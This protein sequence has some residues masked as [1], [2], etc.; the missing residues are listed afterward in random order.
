MQYR[1]LI[2]EDEPM[3][4]KMLERLLVN[5]GYETTSVADGNE[6][7][8]ALQAD[9]SPK[10]A[11]LDWVMPGM[12]G[13]DVARRVRATLSAAD[14]YVYVILITQ[15]ASKEDI[16][17]GIEAGADD[18]IVKPFDPQELRVRIRAGQRL[19][20]LHTGLMAAKADLE[21]ANS[22][23]RREIQVREKTERQLKRARDQLEKRVSARTLELAESN[24]RLRNEIEVRKR[25][26]E[27]AGESEARLMTFFNTAPD[28]IF[29]KDRSLK[30]TVVNPSME[31]LF[32]LPASGIVGR[33]DKELYG[34][35]A[36]RHLIE[37]DSRVI[38]GETIEEEHTRAVNGAPITVLEVRAPMR[39]ATGEVLGICGISRNITERKM[40]A[41]SP[42]LSMQDYSSTA[43]SSVLASA[44]MA[45][46]TDTVILLTGESGT[47]KDRLARY[48]HDHS[49]RSSGPFFSV[50]C[51]A[52]PPELA[53]SELFGHEAGA[54]TGANRR[55][56]GMVELAEGGTLLLNEIGELSLT[57]QAKLLSFLDTFTFTRVG[58]EK[59][60]SVNARLIAATNRD[61][62][63]DVAD[64][65]FRKDLFYRLNVFSISL[66]ALRDR[67][68]DIPDLVSDLTEKLA[69]KLGFR[70]LPVVDPGAME[71]LKSYHWPGNIREL[72]NVL[73]RG[74]ILTNGQSITASQVG[75]GSQT[76]DEK[77]KPEPSYTVRLSEGVT[78]HEALLGV[79]RFLLAEGLR[80]SGS[81]I[82]EAARLLGLSRDS[83]FHHRK[84]LGLDT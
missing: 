41:L 7:W 50:N 77:H 70:K 83:F 2:A 84:S 57:L 46:Q 71:L 8:N 53:E 82:G 51:A 23:L 73:E 11:L 14:R 67:I 49:R 27:T 65:R 47:G 9:Q 1:I 48:L 24:E 15:K 19:L 36:A 35:E 44:R 38:R 29:I 43:M 60:I 34:P 26:E 64:G 59:S 25:A 68:E 20:E 74:L 56:R 5:W 12:D 52:L 37:V 45:A 78:M 22:D 32:E 62:P 80:R 30:Y 66:P 63:V 31:Q 54:Y 28:C 4:R 21:E 6:A 75:L 13:V 40:S 42:K 61:L 55:K 3:S 69:E 79:K 33:T 18:Y 17:A 39:N 10:I 16:I 81:N 76:Q 72:K 58:G